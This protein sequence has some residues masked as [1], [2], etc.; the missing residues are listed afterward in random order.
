MWPTFMEVLW[1]K[2]WF[3]EVCMSGYVGFGPSPG[4]G[5]YG[6]FQPCQ[7]VWEQERVRHSFMNWCSVSTA[8]MCFH[9][10]VG[11]CLILGVFQKGPHVNGQ[12]KAA[13]GLLKMVNYFEA[14]SMCDWWFGGYFIIGLLN[15][16]TFC[17]IYLFGVPP[18]EKLLF[19]IS[20]QDF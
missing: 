2:P 3:P 13:V 14:V 17:M 5:V 1:V 4:V 20:V 16:Y 10:W 12:W 19:L 18:F 15:L 7:R 11:F 8:T 6:R 9:V